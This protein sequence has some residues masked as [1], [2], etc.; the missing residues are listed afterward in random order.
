M[1][2]TGCTYTQ[3]LIM[4]ST[5]HVMHLAANIH[6]NCWGGGLEINFYL[7]ILF[8]VLGVLII[9]FI[10]SQR[11]QVSVLHIKI[12][13]LMAICSNAIIQTHKLC[14]FWQL[15][16]FQSALGS[17]LSA[18]YMTET[19]YCWLDWCGCWIQDSLLLGML[20]NTHSFCFMHSL[21]SFRT[22]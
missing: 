7:R 1:H 8:S 22:L 6:C 16:C 2:W 4:V 11:L 15:F 19:H 10:F 5:A 13:I 12:Y 9:F 18:L 20:M 21:A 17:V 3:K 14:Q